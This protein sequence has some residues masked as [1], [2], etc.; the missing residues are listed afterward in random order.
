[1][2]K[3]QVKVLFIVLGSILLG[4]VLVGTP[5]YWLYH[6]DTS[7]GMVLPAISR[8]KAKKM[9]KDDECIIIRRKEYEYN[10]TGYTSQFYYE[11]KGEKKQIVLSGNDPYNELSYIFLEPEENSFLI[12]G[13]FE[14]KLTDFIGLDVFYV[15]SWY[16]IKPVTRSY[17]QGTNSTD[18]PRPNR[19][20]FS[21]KDGL[22]EYD[23]EQEDYICLSQFGDIFMKWFEVKY[24]AEQE[25]YYLIV[26]HYEGTELKWYLS[27]N[28][29][30]ELDIGEMQAVT[31]EGN[32]PQFV[33]HSTILNNTR[34]NE[35]NY[36]L[37]KGDIS[38][39]EKGND[40]ILIYKWWLS[41]P[42]YSNNIN[43][44]YG[45][46]EWGFTQEDIK[47]EII[48]AYR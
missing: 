24:Y 5:F 15:E 18:A 12:K 21:P 11:E 47:K 16:L 13:Y 17:V 32:N 20:F 33:L 36:F 9:L 31:L 19:R 48:K 34:D 28:Y 22:D 35:Y 37:V 23:V 14:D 25:G 45:D 46:S 39:N 27:Q 40:S 7:Y 1:M 6:K 44:V 4:L 38:K 43:R 26:P 41:R 10:A 8:S 30:P 42:F 2:N 3:Y 29:F